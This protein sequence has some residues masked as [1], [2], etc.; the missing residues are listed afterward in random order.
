MYDPETILALKVPR[1]ADPETKEDF[2]YNRVKVIGPSPIGHS[3]KGDW[4]GADAAGVIIV[5][6]SNFGGTLDEPFGKLREMYNVESVPEPLVIQAPAPRRIID[7]TSP[8]AGKTPEEIF[9]EQAPGVAPEDGQIR[10]RTKPLG[11]PGGPKTADGPLGPAP[12]GTRTRRGNRTS[13]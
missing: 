8:Q 5:P 7:A 10:G 9:A 6:L 12:S 11:E 4:T 3:D 1:P 13:A 2:A